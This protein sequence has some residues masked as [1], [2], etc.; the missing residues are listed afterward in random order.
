MRV[1]DPERSCLMKVEKRALARSERAREH[2][3]RLR[4]RRRQE[5]ERPRRPVLALL[6]MVSLGVGSLAGASWRRGGALEALGVEGLDSVSPAEIAAV[7]GLVPGA[8]LAEIDLQALATRV[9]ELPRIASARATTLPSGRVLLAVVEREPAAVL[10]GEAPLAVDAT[11]VPFAPVAAEDLPDLPRLTSPRAH[12]LGE[13]DAELAEAV[14]L[15]RS[16]P[17]H[18]LPAPSEVAV[19]AAGDAD[20]FSLLLPGLRPRVV[21]GRDA[22][23]ARLADLARLLEAAAPELAQAERVDLR[24]RDQAVLD[25]SPSLEGTAPEAAARGA[26]L[27]SNERP[28]G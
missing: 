26:A 4:R 8:P 7:A 18:G 28:A 21:L 13:A 27:P 2:L 1:F 10:V 16:L 15:A 5:P 14:R 9:A 23:E 19:S 12:A 20:G 22:P 11:G 24:F 3:D 25:V 6:L 17:G